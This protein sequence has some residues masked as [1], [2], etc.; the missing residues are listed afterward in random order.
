MGM[1]AKNKK[2]RV[3]IIASNFVKI[4]AF[5]KKGTEIFVYILL[6]ALKEFKN[7]TI[8]PTTFC[9]GDSLIPSKLESV[10]YRH[11]KDN[12]AVGNGNHMMFELALI[13]KAIAEQSK[14]DLFHVN[15]GNGEFILPFAR[16][17]R[18]PIVITMHNST[19]EPY[20][21]KFFPLYRAQDNVYFVSISDFQRKPL[22][23]LPYIATIQHGIDT[24][25]SFR[26][27]PRGGNAII[28]T[29]RAIPQKGLDIVLTVANKTKKPTRLFPIIKDEYLHW[30]QEEVI[31]K[32]D[33]LDQIVKVHI[34]FNN[35]RFRLVK[36]YQNSKL[37]LF[38][39]KWEEPFGLTIAESLACGTPVVSYARGSLPEIVED[40]KTGFLV[41]QSPKHIRGDWIIKKTGV[42]GLAEAVNRIYSLPEQDYLKMRLACRKQAEERFDM[43]LMADK[44]EDV[45]RRVLEHYAN[46]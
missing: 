21:S 5:T 23:Y 26:F 24:E 17:I 38:P 27:S 15:M 46:H 4:D 29:G 20:N 19:Y 30:L 8:N 14:Y 18:K 13:A 1:M 25:H 22:P 10:I 41:N 35:N 12:P 44:Y 43:R 39:L 42:E 40:G 32:K 7:K 31:K 3:G 34:K 2:I 33:M 36:E 16:F 9:S 6:R 28:W 45:Y 11:T 37:F